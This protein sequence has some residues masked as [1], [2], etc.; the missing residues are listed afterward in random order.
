MLTSGG[1]MVDPGC[2]WTSSRSPKSKKGGTS[3][4]TKRAKSKST[5]LHWRT[6]VISKNAEWEPQCQKYKGRVVLRGDIVKD[7]SGGYAVFTEQG[8]SA[9]QM[10][11]AASSRLPDCTQVKIGGRSRISQNSQVRVPRRMDTS[12]TT[13]MAEILGKHGRSCG[14][15][16][17][18]F[19][20]SSNSRDCYGKDKFEEVLLEF[21]SEKQGM[22]V[23][24]SK[25][26]LF[27][28][29]CVDDV[30]MAGKK[31]KISPMWKKLMKNVDLDEPTSCLDH[32]NLGCTQREWGMKSLLRKIHR[33]LNRVFLLEQLKN[34]RGGQ[35][36][37]KNPWL[38]PTT[39]KD[40]LEQALSDT[41][42]WQTRTWSSFT[43]FQYFC[44]DDHQFK[45][46]ELESAGELSHDCSQF[47]FEMLVLHTNW[48]TWHSVVGQQTCKISHWMDSGIRQTISSFDCIHS[49]HRR[50]PATLS[51][52]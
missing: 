43:K 9:S 40:M 14:T 15:S 2:A 49:S 19:I 27:L 1:K 7:D 18:N 42:N 44:L 41:V 17:T 29:V 35:S 26:E 3:G 5:L 21:G 28:S 46:E 23:W 39:W 30:K 25:T 48:K 38:G 51:C 33:C 22:H 13:W 20:W 6:S 37:A 36:L 47:V 16:W 45:Q 32:V 4:S 24:S 8:S 52:G 50:I 11:A 31:Q 12:S 10:N 34:Y